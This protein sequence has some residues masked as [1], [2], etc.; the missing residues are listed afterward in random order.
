MNP[1]PRAEREAGGSLL[2]EELNKGYE[3]C[4]G[5]NGEEN[6]GLFSASHHAAL[7]PAHQGQPH[8]MSA[9]VA[10]E[11]AGMFANP[12]TMITSHHLSA[13]NG[14]ATQRCPRLLFRTHRCPA[15]HKES[16]QRE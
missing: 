13:G 10:Q 8:P 16:Y 15:G 4:D 9:A 6:Q 11:A 5:R 1:T 14:S 12:F 3:G 2:V 7:H